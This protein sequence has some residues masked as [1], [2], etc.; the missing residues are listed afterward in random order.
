MGIT[1]DPQIEA[2]AFSVLREHNNPNPLTMKFAIALLAL[3]A[4][5]SAT[6]NIRVDKS[7]NGAPVGKYG[8]NPFF[9][10]TLDNIQGALEDVK[11]AGEDLGAKEDQLAALV[12]D[13]MKIMSAETLLEKAVNKADYANSYAAADVV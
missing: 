12:Q 10:G 9:A 13:S 3:A 11:S 7:A 1:N 8:T 2:I 6:P 4:L 5:A